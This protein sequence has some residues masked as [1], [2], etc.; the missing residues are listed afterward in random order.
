LANPRSLRELGSL[1][2]FH[3]RASRSELPRWWAA[4]EAGY[5]TE[6][7]PEARVVSSGPPPP[8]IWSDKKPEA[9]DRLSAARGLLE[10]LSE[11]TGIPAE[12]LLTPDHLRRV[13]WEPPTPL[14]EG[15]LDEFLGS[16]GVRSW[17]RALMTP[18][19]MKAFVPKDQ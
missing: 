4:I 5:T 10:T 17:Q 1:K 14:D 13:C 6:D 9:A 15:K 11:E 16:L 8:R 2:A 7:L 12:N 3:G 18:L 19:L